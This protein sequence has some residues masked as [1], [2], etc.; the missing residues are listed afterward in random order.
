MNN[1]TI[2]KRIPI[3]AVSAP[4]VGRHPGSGCT[5]PFDKMEPGDSFQTDLKKRRGLELA[6]RAYESNTGVKFVVA[7]YGDGIRCWRMI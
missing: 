5:W 2:E 1:V 4:H 3:P 7:K 6:C